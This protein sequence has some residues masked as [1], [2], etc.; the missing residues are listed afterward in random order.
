[1]II[2]SNSIE[3]VVNNN[4]TQNSK[5]NKKSSV[6]E[7]HNSQFDEK[8]LK[9]IAYNK[10]IANGKLNLTQKQKQLDQYL[11]H[12]ETVTLRISKLRKEVVTQKKIISNLEIRKQNSILKLD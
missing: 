3:F 6:G 9:I 11:D 12:L 7:F 1:M 8:T 2:S 10:K 4:S 5:N